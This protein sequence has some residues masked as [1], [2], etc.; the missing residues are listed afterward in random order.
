MSALNSSVLSAATTDV[1]R[2]FQW[3]NSPLGKEYFSASLYVLGLQYC[4]LCDDV[5]DLLL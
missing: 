4:E 2:L 5:V 1:A 3:G